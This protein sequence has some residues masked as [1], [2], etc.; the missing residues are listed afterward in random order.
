MKLL[1][2]ENLSRR[3]LPFLQHDYPGSSQVAMLGLESA[4]DKEV[5]LKA[6]ADG[7]VILT[8]DV[9]F[10]ELSLVWGQPPK[11]IRLK[12]FN[13]SRAATLKLLVEHRDV[14][15]ESLLVQNLASIEI[16]SLR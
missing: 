12:T 15:E 16:V 3:L 1:L 7:F 11:V 2:D 10:Q 14:I 9:D 5:W 13:Q 6:K 8:R 4:S